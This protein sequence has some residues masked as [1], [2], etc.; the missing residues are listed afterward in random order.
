MNVALDSSFEDLFEHKKVYPNLQRMTFDNC[1]VPNHR[2]SKS[3]CRDIRLK[4]VTLKNVSTYATCRAFLSAA[5]KLASV[6]RLEIDGP[7]FDYENSSER[8]QQH[9]SSTMDF[10]EGLNEFLDRFPDTDVLFKY[11]VPNL[12]PIRRVGDGATR[13]EAVAAV[14]KV[15]RRCALRLGGRVYAHLRTLLGERHAELANALLM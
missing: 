7:V 9:L 10:V 1:S 4:C 8:Y 3:D 15:Q 6:E 2:N 13:F 11:V 12:P 14:E 5:S